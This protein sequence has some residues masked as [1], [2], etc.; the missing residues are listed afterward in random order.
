MDFLGNRTMEADHGLF[1]YQNNGS[2]TMD[3][4]GIKTMEPDHGLFRYQN[5]GARPWTF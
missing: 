5:N 1:R 4:L 3:F 2:Q